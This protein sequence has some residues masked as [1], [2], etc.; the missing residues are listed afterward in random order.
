MRKLLLALLAL[1]LLSWAAAPKPS[2]TPD[3][4][5]TVPPGV[6][7]TIT[8]TP[9]KTNT[10]NSIVITVNKDSKVS[11]VET[12]PPVVTPPVVTPPVVTP[13]VVT[14]PVVT[15]PAPPVVTPPAPTSDFDARKDGQWRAWRFDSDTEL[16]DNYIGL[17]PG[18]A[19]FGWGWSGH[20]ATDP[21]RR[22][23]VV[24]TARKALAFELRPFEGANG[25]G[26]WSLNFS[27]DDS[28]CLAPPNERP[29]CAQEVFVQMGVEWDKALAETQFRAVGGGLQGGIKFFDISGLLPRG[30]SDDVSGAAFTGTSS[31][32]KTVIQTDNSQRRDILIY[33]YGRTASGAPANGYG[34]SDG[35]TP[36]NLMPPP[37]CTYPVYANCVNM[38]GGRLWITYREK[39][40]GRSALGDQYVDFEADLWL[41]FD[42][43]PRV[44]V[45]HYDKSTPNYVPKWFGAA[46]YQ[47]AIGVVNLFPYLTEKDPTQDHPIAHAWYYDVIVGP[48]DPGPVGAADAPVV[49]P[50]V[51]AP[52]VVVT[53]PPG[54][55]PAW[56]TGKAVGQ[57]FDIPGTNHMS[58]LTWDE[59]KTGDNGVIR[60]W[61]GLAGG[62]KAGQNTWYS[63]AASGHG[64]WQNPVYALNL[65]TDAPKW[66]ELDHGSA[67]ADVVTTGPY[68]KDGRPTSTHNYYTTVQSG[69]RLFRMTEYATYA[70]AI[71]YDGGPIVNAFRL[72]D[73]KWDAA[74]TWKDVPGDFVTGVPVCAHPETGEIFVLNGNR[75]T[76]FDPKTG[77][78][79]QRTSFGP[80]GGLT[81][82]YPDPS[83][84]GGQQYMPCFVD[85]T[86]NRL[87]SLSWQ[88]GA[89]LQYVDLASG[90]TTIVPLAAASFTSA[91]SGIAESAM[92]HDRDGDRY[93]LAEVST[94]TLWNI[95]KVS[96]ALTKVSDLPVD[97]NARHWPARMQY[98]PDLAGI[99]FYPYWEHDVM[100][101]PTR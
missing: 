84:F 40:L 25:A 22:H 53:P 26:S 2:Y 45:H 55:Y 76:K 79:T 8:V 52:P 89:R 54:T 64:E 100:F 61:N 20:A 51:V 47:P 87:V 6:G 50:P 49:T 11:I 14:P 73:N 34:W 59:P 57:W 42:G 67:Y 66:A 68:N 23:P 80:P 13:P 43:E 19:Q 65:K 91:I 46:K 16:G 71:G 17:A 82:Q 78:Y 88:G 98:F 58:G 56:R 29:G 96:G 24:D 15:P 77:T 41:Q 48:R 9:R 4:T 27:D 28:K 93:L 32:N 74:G 72:S 60:A 21:N 101:L 94:A 39:L 7:K 83:Y 75:V 1:P 86:R 69:D 33:G 90:V 12:A 63:V 37:G 38:R 99:A 5:I 70:T 92:V 62:E 30:T 18:G 3:V 95:D 97:P 10:S 31:A 35:F 44:H 36:Q 85:I 81:P